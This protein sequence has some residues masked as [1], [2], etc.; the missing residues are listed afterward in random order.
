VMDSENSELLANIPLSFINEAAEEPEHRQLLVKLGF[1]SAMV[2]PIKFQ[3][4]TKGVVLFVL[5]TRARSYNEE[6]L[7]MAEE[8]GLRAGLALENSRLFHESLRAKEDLKKSEEK[9]IQV[10]DEA[11]QLSKF[12]SDFVAN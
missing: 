10:R 6:D 1:N 3:G 5:G 8:F 7:R 12:K 11:L 4:Q 9:L 2:V